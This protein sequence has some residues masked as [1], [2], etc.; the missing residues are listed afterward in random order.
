MWGMKYDIHLRATHI[1]SKDNVLAHN[2][3]RQLYSPLKWSM[4]QEVADIF[5]HSHAQGIDGLSMRL[6]LGCYYVFQ[7]T[8]ERVVSNYLDPTDRR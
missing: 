2:L 3:S 1:P 4:K 5:S 8:G 6:N 7:I